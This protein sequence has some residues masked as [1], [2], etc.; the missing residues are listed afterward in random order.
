MGL[1][2]LII[3]NYHLGVLSTSETQILQKLCVSGVGYLRIP[4]NTYRICVGRFS[5][6][7]TSTIWQDTK[8]PNGPMPNPTLTLD[9]SNLSPILTYRPGCWAPPLPLQ[10]HHN[11]P[12]H[13]LLRYRCYRSPVV[14]CCSCACWVV[15]SILSW[16]TRW[17]REGFRV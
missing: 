3:Q 8:I 5:I 17:Q 10:L 7:K 11:R 6:F 4:Q 1:L 13:L 9:Q 14:E 16:Q 12:L 2:L 15:I